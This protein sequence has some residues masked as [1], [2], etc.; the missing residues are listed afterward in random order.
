MDG[1]NPKET[2]IQTKNKK[3]KSRLMSSV[4]YTT[5]DINSS[6]LHSSNF[7]I[8]PELS[9]H[10]ENIS[11]FGKNNGSILF[12]NYFLTIFIILLLICAKIWG[13]AVPL[14]RLQSMIPLSLILRV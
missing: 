7:F 6:F 11:D 5:S 10:L 12:E 9:L 1:S 14:G 8:Q 4:F 3:G 2:E 13:G